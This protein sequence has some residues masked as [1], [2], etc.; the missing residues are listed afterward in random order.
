MPIIHRAER[1]KLDEHRNDTIEQLLATIV[2]FDRDVLTS[3]ADVEHGC[4]LGRRADRR[5]VEPALY[6]H[7]TAAVLVRGLAK[8]TCVALLGGIAANVLAHAAAWLA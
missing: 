1:G 8:V 4:G 6:H 7:G 5:G 3:Q 2:G